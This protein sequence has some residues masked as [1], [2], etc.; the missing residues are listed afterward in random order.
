MTRF[1]SLALKKWG[2][3]HPFTKRVVGLLWNRS[4]ARV[5]LVHAFREIAIE[6]LGENGSQQENPEQKRDTPL[7]TRDTK[8]SDA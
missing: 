5:R 2:L 6:L 8:N 1:S 7:H 3:P 4:S